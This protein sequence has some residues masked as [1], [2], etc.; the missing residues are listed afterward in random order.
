MADTPETWSWLIPAPCSLSVSSIQVSQSDQRFLPRTK[1]PTQFKN[2][3][4]SYSLLIP[5]LFHHSSWLHF[6]PYSAEIPWSHIHSLQTLKFHLSLSF[7]FCMLL[8]QQNHS[9]INGNSH[10][11]SLSLTT[12]P[13]LGS[14]NSCSLQDLP[15]LV[16]CT[17]SPLI[18]I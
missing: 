7:F 12:T 3:I 10:G 18:L 1:L 13:F 4:R 5:S 16:V 11:N 8:T 9:L 2:H 15:T 6:L 17:S 14:P